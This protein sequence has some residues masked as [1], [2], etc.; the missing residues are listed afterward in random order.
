M[1]L[2]RAMHFQVDSFFRSRSA[3]MIKKLLA[4]FVIF[5]KQSFEVFLSIIHILKA[6]WMD[7]QSMQ[8]KSHWKEAGLMVDQVSRKFCIMQEK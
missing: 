4:I 6:V 8:R 2:I 3:Q 1:K 5:G 7:N